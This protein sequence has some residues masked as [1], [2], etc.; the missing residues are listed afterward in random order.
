MTTVHDELMRRTDSLIPDTPPD[1]FAAVLEELSI[2]AAQ[3]NMTLNDVVA[4]G[5][6]D[7]ACKEMKAP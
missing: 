6:Q 5:Y 4:M 3:H 2:I 7:F 1:C